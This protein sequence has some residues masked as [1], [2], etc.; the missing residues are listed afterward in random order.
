MEYTRE[1]GVFVQQVA[2]VFLPRQFTNEKG[3]ATFAAA[4]SVSP[5]DVVLLLDDLEQL[6]V[7][8]Q[9]RLRRDGRR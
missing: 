3:A 4:P 6:H 9:R 5:L 1:S 7:E 2:R 8:H